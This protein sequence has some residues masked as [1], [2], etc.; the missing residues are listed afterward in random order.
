MK[1]VIIRCPACGQLAPVERFGK[2]HALEAFIH[3]FGGRM[4]G[5]RNPKTGK[6]M[7]IMRYDATSF[8]AYRALVKAGLDAAAD[9]L[10]Y[11]LV[12][13]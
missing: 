2:D 10:G 7:G 4:K 6:P 3:I 1:K 12:K 9:K 13:K 8:N 11:R 5:V